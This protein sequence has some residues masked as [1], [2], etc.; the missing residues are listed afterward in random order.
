M[1]K[2]I[3]PENYRTVVFKDMSNGDTFV[4]RSTAN[5]KETI[6]FEGEAL[7][8]VKL[9]ISNTSLTENPNVNNATCILDNSGIAL[10]LSSNNSFA[11]SVA[12]DINID[13]LSATSGSR[14]ILF[15]SFA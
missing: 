14:D 6:D 3:H 1:K 7:P 10:I 4:S 8:V 12:N 11:L 9:D 15:N 13:N 5:A 2:G